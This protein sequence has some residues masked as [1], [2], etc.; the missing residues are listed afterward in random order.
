MNLKQT[1]GILVGAAGII[2]ASY[3]D[4]RA[5]LVGI[6]EYQDINP[7]VGSKQDVKDMA[8]FIQSEWGYKRSQIRTLTDEQA[9]RAGILT[10]FD[11]WLIKG[12]QPGDKVLFYYSGHGTYIRDNNRDESDGY[13]EALCPVDTS[14]SKG[15]LIRDDEI[16]WRLKQLRERQV[17]IIVDACHSGTVTKSAFAPRRYDPTVKVPIFGWRQS[18]RSATKSAF[19]RGGLV[20]AQ[21]NVVVYSAVAAHQVALVDT[22]ARP[23]GPDGAVFTR[24]FIE[25]IRDKKADRNFDGKVSH[26]EVLAYTRRESQAYCDA[27]P[28]QCE[29]GLTPQLEIKSGS[30]N[31]DIRTWAAIIEPVMTVPPYE[32]VEI[33]T[34][35]I[36]L[37]ESVNTSTMPI[38]D[39]LQVDILASR[40]VK[41]G[42]TMRLRVTSVRK[43]GYLLLFDAS[44]TGGVETLRRLFPNRFSKP[45]RIKTGKPRTVPDQ[46]SGCE[47]VAKSPGQRLLVALLADN[48]NELSKLQESFPEVFEQVM[49]TKAYS[50][51]SLNQQLYHALQ[52]HVGNRIEWSMTTVPYEIIN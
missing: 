38:L 49:S 40:P 3:A 32:P 10:A 44:S 27:K 36:T 22:S 8:Q 1:L 19:D 15:N 37:Y 25:G 46:M 12:S 2:T 5:L 26:Q 41:K 4:H 23:Y 45:V 6:D 20:E 42:A 17:M 33:S 18:R 30:S 7:L 35:P 11:N 51:Q 50:S 34:T 43:N 31:E 28:R 29:R 16:H 48:M 9:T 52:K 47:I 24:R 13:D 21:Q 14:H 39:D